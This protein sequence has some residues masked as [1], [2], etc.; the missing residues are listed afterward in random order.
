M[1]ALI[2]LFVPPHIPYCS[3]ST[4][5]SKHSVLWVH[6]LQIVLAIVI[7]IDESDCSGNQKSPPT[8]AQAGSSK[9]QGPRIDYRIQIGSHL[10]V[11]PFGAGHI[12]AF[13]G[14]FAEV[15]VFSCIEP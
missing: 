13:Q 8:S 12:Q 11:S 14:P 4:A 5:H 9:C 7:S 6:E 3:F 2:V 1:L 10:V 15:P